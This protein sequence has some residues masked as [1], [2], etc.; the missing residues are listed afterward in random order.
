MGHIR[1]LE[2]NKTLK[3]LFSI[4][5]QKDF[6]KYWQFIGCRRNRQI[7]I[8][9]IAENFPFAVFF[10]PKHYIFSFVKLVTIFCGKRVGPLCSRDRW[11]LGKLKN[12]PT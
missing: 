8:I 2:N 6:N 3:T 12:E 10:F 5:N 9:A 11:W 1:S 4:E 7:G